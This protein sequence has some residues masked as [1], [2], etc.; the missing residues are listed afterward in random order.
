MSYS[1]TVESNDTLRVRIEVQDDS[2]D[3]NPRTDRD[4]IVTGVVTIPESR[5]ADVEDPT[6]TLGDAWRRLTGDHGYRNRDAVRIFERYVRLLGGVSE[7][8]TPH[9][10]PGAVWYVLPE[11]MEAVGFKAEEITPEKMREA[12]EA[13]RKEYRAWAEGDVYGYVLER[14]DAD[15][16]VVEEL[17]AVWGFIGHEYAEEEARSVFEHQAEED[18][19]K[20][21]EIAEEVPTA[22]TTTI[23]RRYSWSTALDNYEPTRAFA[24]GIAVERDATTG[25][26]EVI[27]LLHSGDLRDAER[28]N[29]LIDDGKRVRPMYVAGWNDGG[30]QLF[31]HPFPTNPGGHKKR[32]DNGRTVDY[33]GWYLGPRRTYHVKV[34]E[35]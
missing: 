11:Y 13:E 28:S 22:M 32:E 33:T 12:L 23:R 10:G 1:E 27:V 15:G 24:Q 26:H 29:Y 4:G 31:L 16:D 14:I 6:G 7:Y 3:M 34:T 19:K 25:D 2:Y 18:R 35:Q 30:S 9:D 21:A 8:D 17:E 5:Y 20:D